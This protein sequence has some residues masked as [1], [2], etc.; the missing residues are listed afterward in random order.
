VTSPAFGPKSRDE[1]EGSGTDQQYT[2]QDLDGDASI[3]LRMLLVRA[4]TST[5][6]R[7][8]AKSCPSTDPATACATG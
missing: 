4:G 5:G 1:D 2:Q 3:H 7:T 8:T 6:S